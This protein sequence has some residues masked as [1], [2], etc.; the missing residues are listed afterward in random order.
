MPTKEAARGNQG[1]VGKVVKRR[2]GPLTR[3]IKGK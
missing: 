3:K 1:G 2:R